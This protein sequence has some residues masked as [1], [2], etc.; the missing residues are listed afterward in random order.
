[1]V[2]SLVNSAAVSPPYSTFGDDTNTTRLLYCKYK[3]A[4]IS[5]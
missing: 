5:E 2:E 1:L 4:P 3:I